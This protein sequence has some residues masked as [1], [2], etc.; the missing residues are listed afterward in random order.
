MFIQRF[1]RSS[2]PIVPAAGGRENGSEGVEPTPTRKNARVV[3]EKL[4]FAGVML[5]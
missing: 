2:E 1:G 4:W 3:Y 5:K